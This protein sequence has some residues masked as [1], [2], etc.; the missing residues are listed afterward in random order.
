MPAR[1]SR[2][3]IWD[4]AGNRQVAL[5]DGAPPLAMS[6]DGS[7]LATGDRD[8]QEPVVKL[9]DTATG[10][11]RAELHDRD[12]GVW[13]LVF[14]PDGTLLLA[15]GHKRKVLWR[16]ADARAVGAARGD[17]RRARPAGVFQP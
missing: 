4:L 6:P 13:P 17:Q 16:V 1:A 15:D 2:V 8:W 7:T 9:W 12:P 5:V 3:Q 11:L 14:S 10:R